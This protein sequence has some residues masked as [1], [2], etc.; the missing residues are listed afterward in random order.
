MVLRLF[1]CVQI[2]LRHLVTRHITV[3]A[4]TKA[5]IKAAVFR[6]HN[7]QP[8]VFERRIGKAE[9]EG[10]E[11]LH[12]L[13]IKP[14]ITDKNSLGKRCFT[15]NTIGSALRMR[16]VVRNVLIQSFGPR[17]RQASRRAGAAQEN[18]CSSSAA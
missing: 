7:L 5:H 1:G 18:I 9:S 12:L 8:R 2:D 15:A 16:K 13:S 10:E 6:T 4:Q 14:A 11:R 3:V 17:K